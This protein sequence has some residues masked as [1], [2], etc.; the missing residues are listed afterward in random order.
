MTLSTSLVHV[1]T[2]ISLLRH[3]YPLESLQED[4]VKL[5]QGF[6]IKVFLNDREIARP[7][8]ID[9]LQGIETEMGF[10]HLKGLHDSDGGVVKNT[11]VYLQGLPIRYNEDEAFHRRYNNNFLIDLGE[12]GISRGVN[13]VHLDSKQFIARVPDR[14]VLIDS[15][16]V[17]QQISSVART[18]CI[19]YLI[20]EKQNLSSE[21]FVNRWWQLAHTYTRSHKND[22]FKALFNDIELIPSH[23]L[24]T[25]TDYPY[26]LKTDEDC[27]YVEP[28]D[29]GLLSKQSLRDDYQVF[30][31]E[32]LT[33]ASY[34]ESDAIAYLFAYKVDSV[35]VLPEMDDI[36]HK[37][38]WIY[39]YIE[40]M[41]KPA[42]QFKYTFNKVLK[43][44]PFKTGAWVD[45]ID[46]IFCESCD[47]QHRKSGKTVTI[48]ND[49][50]VL[51]AYKGVMYPALEQSGDIVTQLTLFVDEWDS[52]RDD[53]QDDEESLFIRFVLSERT[54][55]PEK[56][57]SQLLYSAQAG[58]YSTLLNKR[59]TVD[60]AEDGSLTVSV[61]S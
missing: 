39:D 24:S 19:E 22:D 27:Q 5:A 9:Q 31:L 48:D 16:A 13:I 59:F 58:K 23:V 51:P 1:G 14:D 49:A 18:V 28:C 17:E 57:L 20:Q 21:D 40:I 29:K 50:F 44:A 33:E 61:L 3:D 2:T 36:F 42:E 54:H 15:K 30:K 26:I 7:H 56:L 60:I 4:I 43:T 8:A 41:N 32:A 6:P 53:E 46:V 34:E 25:V 35:L 38:H 12:V 55:N 45:T 11:Q 47:V 37:D 52:W 10:F